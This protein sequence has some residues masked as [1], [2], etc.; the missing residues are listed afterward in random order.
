MSG[1]LRSGGIRPEFRRRGS[2]CA[3]SGIAL[4]CTVVRLRPG[5]FHRTGAFLS[6]ARDAGQLW[7]LPPPARRFY[8]AALRTAIRTRDGYALRV[9]LPPRELSGLL[10]LAAGRSTVVELGTA[11]GW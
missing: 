4:T 11:S 3:G 5:A 2:P 7:R 10:R 6:L 1:T 9:S 8:R